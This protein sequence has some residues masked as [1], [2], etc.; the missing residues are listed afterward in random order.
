MSTVSWVL[1]LNT[2]SG[3]IKHS[4]ISQ[5]QITNVMD[6]ECRIISSLHYTLQVLLHMLQLPRKTLTNTLNKTNVHLS[7]EESTLASFQSLIKNFFKKTNSTCMIGTVLK[8]VSK[9]LKKK[10]SS[11][12]ALMFKFK[13]LT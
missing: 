6:A 5:H 8:R 7:K 1:C 4:N 9:L 12:F 10:P 11:Y 3:T 2:V 13:S